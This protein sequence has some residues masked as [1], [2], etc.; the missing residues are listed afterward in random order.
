M[1][2][3]TAL[4]PL[5]SATSLATSH[6][7]VWW[8]HL[9]WELEP[10]HVSVPPCCPAT[11]CILDN[12][13]MPRPH[14]FNWAARPSQAPLTQPPSLLCP[15]PPSLLCPQPPSL[16]CP[17]SVYIILPHRES[18]SLPKPPADSGKDRYWVFQAQCQIPLLPHTGCVTSSK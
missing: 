15:Q 18:P 6:P 13:Q 1:L 10:E 11:F 17:M 12:P 16:L 3:T 8:P 2:T 14:K 9:C 7:L 4:A 5:S